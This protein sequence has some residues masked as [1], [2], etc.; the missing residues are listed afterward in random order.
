MALSLANRLAFKRE[1]HL[2]FQKHQCAA[3]VLP[4][5]NAGENIIS[6]KIFRNNLIEGNI[7]ATLASIAGD[8]DGEYEKVKDVLKNFP[9]VKAEI[10]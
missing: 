8:I 10:A 2:H 4:V 3:F 5:M 9:A 1:Q 6:V 7:N